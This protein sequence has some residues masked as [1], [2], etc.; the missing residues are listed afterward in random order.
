MANYRGNPHASS[1]WTGRAL[2]WGVLFVVLAGVV[3]FFAQQTRVLHGQAELAAIQSTLGSLRTALVLDHLQ[4]AAKGNAAD[5]ATLQRNPFKL[6]RSEGSN[7]AGEFDRSHIVDANPGS[8][9]FDK[10]CVCVGYR[11]MHPEWAEP[12]DTPVSLWFKVSEPPG[13]L[14]LTAQESYLWQGQKV[15]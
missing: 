4:R 1:F 5:V 7:Y 13:P 9:V 10:D 6:V 14:Q 8:W 15:R 11:P 2:E 12:T 3:G